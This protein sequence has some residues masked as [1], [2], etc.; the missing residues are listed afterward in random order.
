MLSVTATGATA[1]NFKLSFLYNGF[2]YTTGNIAFNATGANIAT[3]ILAA[4]GGPNNAA[5]STVLPAASITGGGTAL[6]G[7][8]AT[9]TASGAAEGRIQPKLVNNVGLTG[10]SAVVTETTQGSG[11]TTP[12]P[13]GNTLTLATVYIP[14]TATSSANYTITAASLPTS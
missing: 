2:L 7:G 1:G 3:A 8:P 11:A 10:G 9:V 12:Y 6:P 4:T 14:S 5:L 13:S